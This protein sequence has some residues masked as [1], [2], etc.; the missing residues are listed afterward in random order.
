MKKSC[1][2]VPLNIR[3]KK[4]CGPEFKRERGGSGTH[5]LSTSPS[6]FEKG[7]R[8]ETGKSAQI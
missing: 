2:N 3:P 4:C 1:S 7:A 8:Y 6:S 5:S